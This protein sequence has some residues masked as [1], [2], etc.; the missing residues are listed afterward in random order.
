MG[1]SGGPFPRFAKG[2]V[3][4]PKVF[5]VG[6]FEERGSR[7]RWERLKSETQDGCSFY[8]R[9]VLEACV[10]DFAFSL[11]LPFRVMEKASAAMHSKLK[12]AQKDEALV[13]Q[14]LTLV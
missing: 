13:S 8:L 7:T 1:H 2:A 3:Y 11:W 4:K 12:K 5:G 10:S 6:V 9:F 14:T